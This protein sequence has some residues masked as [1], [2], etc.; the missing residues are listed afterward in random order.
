MASETKIKKYYTESWLPR[1]MNGHNS[2]SLAM[3][4]GYFIDEN[5][6][7]DFAKLEMNKFLVSNFPK[8]NEQLT[9]VDAGCG[10]G[11]TCK[12]LVENYENFQVIGVNL[13][14]K[15]IEFAQQNIQNIKENSS[16]NFLNESYLDMSTLSNSVDVFF[17]MESMCHA[18]D[19]MKFVQ[20]AHRILKDEGVCLIFDYFVTKENNSLSE[21]EQ[22]LLTDFEKGWAVS[23]YPDFTFTDKL[24]QVGFSKTKFISLTDKVLPGIN[25]SYRKA[26][27][28]VTNLNSDNLVF[29]NHLK[30]NIA[31]K[32]LIDLNVIDYKMIKTIK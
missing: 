27:N 17:A 25:H 3:H 24:H 2:A 31:L 16:I 5:T 12:Y 18:T 6:P 14:D 1:F 21:L 32:K 30:A 10:V 26:V 19:K 22:N 29:V 28:L 7:N 9:I 20:E 15:Q 13:H 23:H 11:G 8:N 4:M